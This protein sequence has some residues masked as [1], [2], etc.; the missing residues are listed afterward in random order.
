MTTR[1]TLLRTAIW[2]LAIVALFG[3]FALY[4]RPDLVF[5]LATQVWACF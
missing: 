2:S 5:A 1:R 3:V 4:L